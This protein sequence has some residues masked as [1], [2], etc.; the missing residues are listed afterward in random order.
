MYFNMNIAFLLSDAPGFVDTYLKLGAELQKFGSNVYYFSDSE[1]ISRRYESL[2]GDGRYL[3]CFCEYARNL[4]RDKIRGVTINK[5][6]FADLERLRL[7]YNASPTDIDNF[8]QKSDHLNGFFE[9]WI[10]HNNI[11]VLISE[12]VAGSYTYAALE[13]AKKCK[14][15]FLGYELSRI[16]GLTELYFNGEMYN[17]NL[18]RES[19]ERVNKLVEMYLESSLSGRPQI[20]SYM[21]SGS[22]FNISNTSLYQRLTNNNRL[23]QLVANLYYTSLNKKNYFGFHPSVK[24][25]IHLKLLFRRMFFRYFSTN[26]KNKLHSTNPDKINIIFPLH[27]HPEA[28]TSIL[29]QEYFCELD[30]LTYLCSLLPSTFTVFI[31]EHPSM[32]GRRDRKEK[33][34]FKRLPNSVFIDAD[35]KLF[36]NDNI[37]AVVTLT[38]TMGLEYALRSRLVITFGSVFYNTHPNVIRARSKA[39]CLE[40]LMHLIDP[41]DSITSNEENYDY[42]YSY[43]EKCL[44]I[45]FEASS[46]T[47]TLILEFAKNIAYVLRGTQK[48]SGQ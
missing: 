15:L 34:E 45:S 32:L 40:Q 18:P 43:G 3:M 10:N 20:P 21:Q 4:T 23:T 35:E 29:S 7:Y 17:L 11:S 13:S 14:I 24:D 26:D 33:N 44:P 46:C 16:N 9:R 25:L 37:K 36:N 31:K 39:E 38:G 30:I 27:F 48:C 28:A 19:L 1:T 8:F 12:T 47:E 22:L 5:G 41:S 42:L 6:N 2:G